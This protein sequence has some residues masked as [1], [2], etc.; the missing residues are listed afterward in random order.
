MINKNQSCD[1]NYTDEQLRKILTPE[2]YRVVRENGTEIP[3]RNDYWDNKR[4]GIYVDVVSGEPLF[5][6]TDKFDSGTGWPSF[7]I[8]VERR[9]V[10]SIQDT[11]YGMTRTEVRSLKAGSHLGH[12]FDD[13]PAPTGLRYCIN[14]ASLRFIP[15]EQ[16][17]E[18]GYAKLMYL[19]PAEYAGKRGWDFIVFGAGCFW[20]TEAYFSH[21][22]GVKEVISGYAGGDFPYPSYEEVCSGKTGHAEV[23]LVYYDPHEISTALLLKHFFRMH[24]PSS[25]NRQGNDT[26]T[27]YRSSV[28]YHDTDQKKEIDIRVKILAQQ[29]KYKSI[30]TEIAGFR[31]FYKAEE[32]HQDYLTKNP[33]GYCHVNLNMLDEPIGER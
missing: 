1:L 22:S 4:P 3:F 10:R 6:S 2:Q 5:S 11:N 21:I 31:N 14:S 27:Q 32:Y 17:E 23:V 7:I 30:V 24:D 9:P 15:A 16:M 33:G 8:P 28:F 25:L 19:F 18:K 26:G 20:G 12:L 13:G 29:G